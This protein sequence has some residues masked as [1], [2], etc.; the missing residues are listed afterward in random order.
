MCSCSGSSSIRRRDLRGDQRFTFKHALTREVAY[1]GLTKGQRSH[2]HL[3]YATWLE[4]VRGGPDEDS[5]FLAHHYAE[6]ASLANADVV[7]SGREAEH[8]RVRATAARWLGRAADVAYRR[9]AV[10]ESASMLEQAVE[11]EPDRH[12]QAA[13]LRA[14][15]HSYA[16]LYDGEAFQAA[17]E[18]CAD[19]SDDL[20]TRA[21]VVAELAYQSLAA[22]VALA[23]TAR[24]RTDRPLDHGGA[25]AQP[26]ADGR[27][28]HGAGGEVDLPF[29]RRA[30]GRR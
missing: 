4:A 27:P 9:G 25:R 11:L 6:A 3:E 2:L 21:E 28:R 12:R 24:Q 23:T 19:L 18:R 17:L 29:V 10:R 30:R 8:A 15:A 5:P 26:A 7:W 14:L 13:L 20:E 1:H 22:T 16:V